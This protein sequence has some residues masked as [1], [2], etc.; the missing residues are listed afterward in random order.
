MKKI[1]IYV[2]AFMTM[3]LLAA[4]M[5]NDNNASDKADNAPVENMSTNDQK[6]DNNTNNDDQNLD[7]AEKAADRVKELEEVDDATVLVT[8]H[9]AYA[10]VNLKNGTEVND[11]LKNRIEEKV[12]EADTSVEKVY[13]SE[14]P[15]FSTQMKD[16]A[17]RIKAGD[18]IGG[19]FDE[20][21]DSVRR[22]FP[23]A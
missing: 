10:A 6:A 17:D 16:Y 11:D 18:P 9:T 5:N 14:D 8:D 22:V 1:S 4:C 2:T 19:F 23:S 20:F 15:D 7:V 3:L 21:S 12:K 13:V